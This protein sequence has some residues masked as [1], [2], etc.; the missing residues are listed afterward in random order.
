MIP[1][2][3]DRDVAFQMGRVCHGSIVC[4]AA[5]NTCLG[6]E[7]LGAGFGT[8]RPSYQRVMDDLSPDAIF[9]RETGVRCRRDKRPCVAV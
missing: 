3:H 2:A 4:G 1:E 7:I 6:V 8:D 9:P 5:Q